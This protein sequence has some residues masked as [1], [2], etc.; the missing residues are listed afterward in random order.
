M[1]FQ[2]I[3]QAVNQANEINRLVDIQTADMAKLIK[4][5]L[6]NVTGYYSRKTLAALKHELKDF[7]AR[8]LTWKDERND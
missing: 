2:D 5:R 8:T 7:N 6:R 4:G 1:N 3:K